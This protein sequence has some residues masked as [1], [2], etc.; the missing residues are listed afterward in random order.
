MTRPCHSMLSTAQPCQPHTTPPL[1]LEQ[2]QLPDTLCATRDALSWWH[3]G[4][5]RAHLPQSLGT[6]PPGRQ[7]CHGR[8]T[9]GRSSIR[10]LVSAPRQLRCLSLTVL[11]VKQETPHLLLQATVIITGMIRCI[12]YKVPGFMTSNIMS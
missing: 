5:P 7:P 3:L 9:L 4:A 6:A 2:C 10:L 8:K 11:T 1:H 12:Y